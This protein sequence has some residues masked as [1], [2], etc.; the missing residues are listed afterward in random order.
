[1]HTIG[2]AEGALD[3]EVGIEASSDQR[4]DDSSGQAVAGTVRSVCI[5][6]MTLVWLSLTDS[7]D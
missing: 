6:L 3:R 4:T 5:A 2:V 1:M 7:G